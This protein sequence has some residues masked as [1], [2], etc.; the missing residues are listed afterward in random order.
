M[1]ST[2]F[3]TQWVKIRISDLLPAIAVTSAHAMHT[4]TLIKGRTREKGRQKSWNKT[5]ETW[6]MHFN[7]EN[8]MKYIIYVCK[9]AKLPQWQTI[10]RSVQW[11]TR[12]ACSETALRCAGLGWTVLC[13]A[14]LTWK[15]LLP[16]VG[17]NAKLI[18]MLV[19]VAFFIF[20]FLMRI[21]FI[22]AFRACRT[23]KDIKTLSWLYL[24]AFCTSRQRHSRHS[25]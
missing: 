22:D 7:V 13:C 1:S 23:N 9:C 12:Q 21:H 17:L 10:C 14:V 5:L 24:S 18:T 16:V 6:T 20:F 8:C 15:L 25:N 4:H 2:C 3:G 11:I 19:K